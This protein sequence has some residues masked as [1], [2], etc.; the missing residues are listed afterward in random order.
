MSQPPR[1]SRP[2]AGAGGTGQS[3]RIGR[4][5]ASPGTNWTI[6][7]GAAV[8]IVAIIAGLVVFRFLRGS[9]PTATADAPISPDVQRALTS[10][11][12]A[13]ANQIGL[14]T[15]QNRYVAVRAPL[16]KGPDGKPEVLYIGAEFC[17]YCAAER[18][19]MVVALSRFGSFSGLETTTSAADDV[20]PSTPTLTFVHASYQSQYVSFSTVELTTNQRV[21]GA[22]APLQTP[23]PNQNQLMNTYDAPPYVSSDSAGSIPFVDIANQ[24]VL[25]GATYSPGV[26]DGKTWGQI[27]TSLSDPSTDVAKSI[28]GAANLMTA[29]VCQ[30]TSDQPSDVC[31]QPAVKSLE[32]TLAK[33]AV[34]K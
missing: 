28:V 5:A 14:G 26:L 7:L 8:V 22:Y 4:R 34:P 18:W 6:I 29:A 21:N 30:A 32:D 15:A 13:E 33:E 2:R 16:L 3:P 27:A 24:Y 20:F 17:P 23:T 9:A 1:P 19:A 10:V 31:G 12:V 11:P 25:A